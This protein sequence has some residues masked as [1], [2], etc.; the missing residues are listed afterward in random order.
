MSELVAGPSYE[1]VPRGCYPV[2]VERAEIGKGWVNRKTRKPAQVLYLHCKILTGPFRN[3]PLFLPLKIEFT[4]QRPR[5][6]SAFFQAW[7]VAMDR[8]PLRGERMRLDVFKGKVFLAEITT[9]TRDGFGRIRPDATHYS[10]ISRLLVLLGSELGWALPTE[11]R[12]PETEHSTPPPPGESPIVTRDSETEDVVISSGWPRGS[13]R[14]IDGGEHARARVRRD[15]SPG[16]RPP[17]GG[18]M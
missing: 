4:G 14:S 17:S 12:R 10:R 8:K 16:P 7:V 5:L 11:D 2:L 3:L 18:S 9:V 13:A 15:T 1:L 6:S